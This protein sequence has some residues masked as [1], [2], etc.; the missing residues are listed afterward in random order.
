MVKGNGRA[1]LGPLFIMEKMAAGFNADSDDWRYV[2]IM[3]N[4]SIFGTTNGKSSDKVEFCIGCHQSVTPEQDNVMLLP[5][6]FR[7]K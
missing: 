2:M 6:E 1:A 7:V 4:G 5:E 3:P